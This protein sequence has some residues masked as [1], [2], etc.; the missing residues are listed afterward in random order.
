MLKNW[1]IFL[2]Y[3]IIN[4]YYYNFNFLT[5]GNITKQTCMIIFQVNWMISDQK[6]PR[7]NHLHHDS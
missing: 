1:L 5:I 2:G 4:H 7:E 6:P 3:S